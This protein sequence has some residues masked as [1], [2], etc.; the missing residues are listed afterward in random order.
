[1]VLKPLR[2][3]LVPSP[4]EESRKFDEFATQYFNKCDDLLSYTR[5]YPVIKETDL[6]VVQRQNRNPN[7]EHRWLRREVYLTTRITTYEELKHV[8]F[9]NRTEN[10]PNWLPLLQK[11]ESIESIVPNLCEVYRYCFKSQGLK[12]KRDYCQLVLKREFL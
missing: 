7:E 10:L 11:V 1:M 3:S 6:M 9:L 8:L 12:A 2:R 5:R 4:L